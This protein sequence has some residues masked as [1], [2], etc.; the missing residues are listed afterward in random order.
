[1]TIIHH[2]SDVV[3][4][5]FAN[6]TLDDAASLVVGMHIVQCS[7]CQQVVRDCEAVG[8]AVLDE[9]APNPML[10]DDA[11]AILARATA[12][13]A[14]DL[15]ISG[16]HQEVPSIAPPNLPDFQRSPQV[17]RMLFLY[18]SGKWRWAGP[19]VHW[20]PL[21]VP[22]DNNIR[23]FI[24]KAASGVQLPDHKHSGIEWTC[25]LDGAFSHAHG[26]FGPG[27]FDEADSD[28]EHDPVVEP[29]KDCICIVA[30]TGQL[31]LQGFLGKIMQ[32][33]VRF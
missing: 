26:R 1:M 29:G 16:E 11:E 12:P 33:F 13:P 10:V 32:P 15:Q 31:E 21:S 8:G 25:V 24:L 17:D 22:S 14:A 2:P 5:E 28:I 23:V 18:D 7:H 19:G 3:L 20:C 4:A 27:D 9:A 6:S 30:M